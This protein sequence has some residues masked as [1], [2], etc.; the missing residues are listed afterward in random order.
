ME[1]CAYREEDGPLLAALS[2]DTVHTVNAGDYT[3]EQ[4]AA[5]APDGR[6]LKAWDRSFRDHIA[7]VAEEQGII[8][9]F[10]DLDPTAEYLGPALCSPV[11]SGTRCGN[12][13]V[14]CF[15]GICAELWGTADRDPC[16]HYGPPF[17]ARRG[18]RMVREQQVRRGEVLLTNFVME[19]IVSED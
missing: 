19:K 3:P 16:V 5:W 14:C 17:F 1:L 9:G 12:C 7:L 11:V 2:Y 6:D 8:V 18:Y 10:A 15:G 13:P 4:L